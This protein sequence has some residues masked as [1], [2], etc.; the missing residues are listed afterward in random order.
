MNRRKFIKLLSAAIPCCA[1]GGFVGIAL[2]QIPGKIVFDK[3]PV[4]S[5]VVAKEALTMLENQLVH[6]HMQL[7]IERS[8]QSLADTIDRDIMNLYTKG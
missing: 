5:D 3:M 6:K 4:S 2:P 8:A 7:A 1:I